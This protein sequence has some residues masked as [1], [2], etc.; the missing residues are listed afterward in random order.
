MCLRIILAD[1]HPFVLLGFRAMLATHAGVTIVGQALTPTS[2]IELLQ[3]TPCDLLV[4]DLS[5]PD[6]AG[7]IEDGPGLVR[8]IR[9]GWPLLRIIVMTTQTNTS[10]LRGIVSD[11]AVSALGKTE[12]LDE[13]WQAIEAC[14][15]GVRYL[16][17]S[18][19]G[20]LAHQRDDERPPLSTVR[21]STRQTEVVKRFVSGQSI[22]QIAAALGCH[23]RTISR[24]KREAMTRLGVTSNSGL[25]SRVHAYGI[26]KIESHI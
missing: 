24:Q 3:S 2:L 13:L 18:I 7:A 4:T 10:I 6:E 26:F 25:F 14:M 8:R 5:M 21:L 20:A 15:N 11:G 1:D 12:S 16:G 19:V 23:R 17:R 9:D 22:A